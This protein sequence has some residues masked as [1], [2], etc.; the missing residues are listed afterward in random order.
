MK[1]FFNVLPKNGIIIYSIPNEKYE[2]KKNGKP[3]NHFHKHL[4][5]KQDIIDL[6][7]SVGFNIK[8]IS[9]QP[10][11]NLLLHNFKGIIKRI[12]EYS[13]DSEDK[14]KFFSRL[15]AFPTKRL[16]KYTYS[17]IIVAQKP[18]LS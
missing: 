2:P 8:S 11:S 10:F 3:S 7:Q 12:D 17:Y 1:G 15:I 18:S 13:L 14:F 5:S 6:A 16:L 4:F 9:G